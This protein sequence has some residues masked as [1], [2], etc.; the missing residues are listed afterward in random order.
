MSEGEAT[1]RV[2]VY[3][4]GDVRKAGISIP[5]GGGPTP[6][7]SVLRGLVS[8]LFSADVAGRTE[9][10]WGKTIDAGGATA[11]RSLRYPDTLERAWAA[12][13]VR[14]PVFLCFHLGAGART[15]IA[16]AFSGSSLR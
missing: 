11:A 10:L 15:H 6:H 5:G 14:Q 9:L 12:A 4:G 16:R 8:R 7:Y 13:R 1:V 3:Y 2:A